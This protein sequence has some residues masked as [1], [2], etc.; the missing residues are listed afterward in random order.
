LTYKRN[1]ADENELLVSGSSK[2]E[3]P[4]E[5]NCNRALKVIEGY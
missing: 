3:E 1:L 5:R 2:K 4:K